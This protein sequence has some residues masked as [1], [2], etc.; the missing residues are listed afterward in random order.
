MIRQ[1]WRWLTE[2]DPEP[3][4]RVI[5]RFG[6]VGLDASSGIAILSEP[7]RQRLCRDIRDSLIDIPLEE[8]GEYVDRLLLR[9]AFTVLD[10]PASESHHH[11]ARFGLLDHSL[12]VAGRVAK[13][14]ASPAFRTTEDYAADYREKPLWHYAAVVCALLHDVGKVLDLEV[15]S[16]DGKDRWDPFVEPLALFCGRHRM[17]QTGPELWTHR[18]GRGVRFHAWHGPMLYPLILPPKATPYLGHRLAQLSDALIAQTLDQAPEA[19]P[20]VPARI[21]KIIHDADVEGSK[22]DRQAT[23]AAPEPVVPPTPAPPVPAAASSPAPDPAPELEDNE[24]F[25]IP[26]RCPP[27]DL[28]VVLRDF[29]S[30]L[31]AAV[32]QGRIPLNKEGGLYVGRRHVY[33]HYREGMECVIDLMIERGSDLLDRMDEDWAANPDRF[34][35]EF[36][37]E[38]RVFEALLAGKRMPLSSDTKAWIQEGTVVHPGGET[39]EAQV[40]LLDLPFQDFP[41]FGGTL[42]LFGI[43]DPESDTARNPLAPPAEPPVPVF[44]RNPAEAFEL[45]LGA[46]LEPG[47]LLSTLL[48]ALRGRI[49]HRPGS[50]SPVLVRPDFTWVLFPEAF[51]TLLSRIGLPF[52]TEVENGI[53]RSFEEMPELARGS[54][55]QVLHRIR[56][57]PESPDLVWALAI[58]TS[59]VRGDQSGQALP[60]WPSPVRVVEDVPG[61]YAA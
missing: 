60:A 46:E 9:F 14:V 32:E 13:A 56:V 22:A 1:F 37:P 27:L 5:E 44:V 47:R 61:E 41:R 43:G 10:L 30:A 19:T 4:P 34:R 17:G 40:V 18:V 16:P 38:Q 15:R 54:K 26:I 25:V 39:V 45:R 29:T 57:H 21:A 59:W 52:S 24:P 36:S 8:R 51:K 53:L 6:A 31:R 2:V 42:D 35:G 49:F 33:L 58:D 12:E 23:L 7:K 20:D 28:G 50:W 11:S 48:G 3:K 55:G